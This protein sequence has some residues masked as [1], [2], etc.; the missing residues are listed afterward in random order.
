MTEDMGF[1]AYMEEMYEDRFWFDALDNDSPEP[2]YW[3]DEDEDVMFIPSDEYDE[4]PF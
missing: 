1:D 4:P 3:G 2:P